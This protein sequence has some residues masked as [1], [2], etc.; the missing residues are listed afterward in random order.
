MP[1]KRHQPL[2][3][4]THSK[5]TESHSIED[6][7]DTDAP[8]GTKLHAETSLDESTAPHKPFGACFACR[9]FKV[10]CVRTSRKVN[11]DS[12]DEISCTHCRKLGIRCGDSE[13][14]VPLA[15]SEGSGRLGLG[16][17]SRSNELLTDI[18]RLQ[19]R[20]KATF[21]KPEPYSP[22]NQS[23]ST[24]LDHLTDD[25][26]VYTTHSNHQSESRRFVQLVS[27]NA[28]VPTITPNLLVYTSSK[29]SEIE[30]Q[31]NES[32]NQSAGSLKILEQHFGP[33]PYW[34]Y[35]DN[36]S[37]ISRTT[38]TL[39]LVDSK[40]SVVVAVLRTENEDYPLV[41][42][43]GALQQ[44]SSNV[45]DVLQKAV[46]DSGLRLESASIY[47]T[48]ENLKDQRYDDLSFGEIS[49]FPTIFFIICI[50]SESAFQ[51]K[52]NLPS[53]IGLPV[54]FQMAISRCETLVERALSISIMPLQCLHVSRALLHLSI[55]LANSDQQ[56]LEEL[57]NLFNLQRI[58]DKFDDLTSDITSLPMVNVDLQRIKDRL[59]RVF[60]SCC[61]D[62][63]GAVAVRQ[64]YD[65][66]MTMSQSDLREWQEQGHQKLWNAFENC[67]SFSDSST[68]SEIFSE[69]EMDPNEHVAKSEE[70]KSKAASIVSDF[71]DFS[72]NS[73]HTG[74]SMMETTPDGPSQVCI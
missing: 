30:Q 27:L 3:D 24:S 33:R 70:Q 17:E 16:D 6:Q 36:N 72:G 29:Y 63:P 25:N 13:E 21:L 73:D 32:L 62:Y 28:D 47:A 9:I 15:G 31:L 65:V 49:A 45:L 5:Q 18:S 1:P 51:F 66:Y 14:L 52:T 8:I 58:I 74:P 42:D 26:R 41:I 20:N 23:P 60:L 48:N 7:N 2:W 46:N 4:I 39:Y 11:P 37:T 68:D 54:P 57:I 55:T 44:K 10:R 69:Y 40:K 56:H 71:M 67:E 38:R 35:P 64:S 43:L 12:T 50:H 53:S 61:N 22:F 19:A 34:K 59:D